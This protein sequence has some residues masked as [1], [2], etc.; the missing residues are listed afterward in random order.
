MIQTL[1]GPS[2]PILTGRTIDGFAPTVVFVSSSP[3]CY[4]AYSLE[5]GP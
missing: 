4:T 1:F 5:G 3:D 2:Y